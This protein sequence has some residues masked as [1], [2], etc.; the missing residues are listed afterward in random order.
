VIFTAYLDESGTHDGSQAVSVAGYVSTPEAWTRFEADW[1]AALDDF[2]IDMFHMSD[3][4]NRAGDFQRWPNE[5]RQERL[6]R[7]IRIINTNVIA[8]FG[9]TIMCSQYADTFSSEAHRF[10]GGPYGL[11]AVMVM[12]DLGKIL[13]LTGALGSIA[14]VFESGALGAGQV[15]QVFTANEQNPKQ[16]EEMRLLSLRFENKRDFVPLQAA[17]ILAY[18]LYKH[19]PRQLGVEPWS[20]GPRHSLR[21]LAN[22]PHDWGHADKEQLQIFSEIITIRAGL[23]N[24]QLEPYASAQVYSGAAVAISEKEFQDRWRWCLRLMGRRQREKVVA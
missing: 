19:L 17:D 3:F 7:L 10:V 2:G 1:R 21:M 15:L 18:E 9:T 23:R 20:R 13:R 14:Y 5:L 11:A 16:K 12:M 8:S 24:D 22:V 4:E 6:A